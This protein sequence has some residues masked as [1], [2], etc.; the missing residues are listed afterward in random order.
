MFV[1]HTI[2]QIQTFRSQLLRKLLIID[3]AHF[4]GDYLGTMFLAVGMDANNQVM[5][6]AI[7][8][9]K[10]ESGELCTY[11]LEMLKSVSG[12]WMGWFS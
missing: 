6:I 7:G 5:P 9:A 12:K 1:N 4:N 2:L 11:F 3:G 10:A 8:V